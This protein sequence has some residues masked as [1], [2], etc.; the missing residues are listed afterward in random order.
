MTPHEDTH[1]N[2]CPSHL[3]FVTNIAEMKTSLL[4]IEKGLTEDAGFKRGISTAFIGVFVTIVLQI[5]VFAFLQGGMSKQIEI[6]TA[7]LAVIESVQRDLSFIV[8][9][10]KK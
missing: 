2:Y 10:V 5:S 7:R 1:Y 3:E 9:E 8:Q 6:N 4:N